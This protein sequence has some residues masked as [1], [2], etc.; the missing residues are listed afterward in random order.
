MFASVEC[1]TATLT[2]PAAPVPVLW[3]PPPA[4]PSMDRSAM[5]AASA[6]VVPVSVQTPSSKGQPVRCV[7]PALESVLSIKNVF[8]AEPS[9]KEKRKTHV[10][11]NVHIS[12]LPRLKIGTNCPSQARWIP[13][14]T[15]RRRM[16]TTAG[17]TS[18]IQ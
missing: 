11:R 16:L 4:W 13:C 12:T 2:T 14:P 18:H 7:R 9:I 3:M 5:A 17:S 1:V 8:S 10:L 6:S 15:V